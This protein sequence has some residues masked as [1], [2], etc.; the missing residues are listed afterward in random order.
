[1]NPE[2]AEEYTKGLG[3]IVAGVRR[4]MEEGARLGVPEALGLSANEWMDARLGGSPG[5]SSPEQAESVAEPA[6]SEDAAAD[7]EKRRKPLARKIY[8]A[9]K[10]ESP[11]TSDKPLMHRNVAQMKL[12]RPPRHWLVIPVC[13]VLGLFAGLILGASAPPSYE[14]QT[15][16]F[17]SMTSLPTDDPNSAD[18]FGGS[19]FALQRIQSYAEIAT[20]PQVLQGAL[21]DLHRGD[22][23][24]LSKNVKVSSSGGVMLWVTVDDG[25]P[26]A[27][28]H[29]ADAVMAN[30]VRSV[31]ALEA[32]GGQHSPVQL[33]PVQPALVPDEPVESGAFVTTLFG[34][35]VGLCIGGA[36]YYLIRK[37]SGGGRFQNRAS[38]SGSGLYQKAVKDEDDRSGVVV[39][40]VGDG[41]NFSR[42]VGR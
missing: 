41:R 31:A 37:R 12:R 5:A 10:K 40:R 6:A 23:A 26:K 18:P 11:A 8:R 16:A 22:G 9:V 30:L 27:A 29:M 7:G 4:Q 3:Q 15:A 36:A 38:N 34:L 19:Q 32:S 1:M 20:S 13:G 33:V 28:A 14:S 25:D 35:L 42:T 21:R 39:L 2:D 17:V 24:D